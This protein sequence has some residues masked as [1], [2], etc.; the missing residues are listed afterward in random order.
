MFA[1]FLLRVDSVLRMEERG[2]GAWSLSS[3][4]ML[5][6]LKVERRRAEGNGASLNTYVCS[7]PSHGLA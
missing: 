7:G 4:S 2:V 5:G 6:L 3:M 1:D